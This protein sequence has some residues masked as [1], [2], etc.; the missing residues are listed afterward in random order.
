MFSKKLPVT[1]F[2]DNAGRVWNAAIDINTVKRVR[3]LTGVDI[4]D[5][6]KVIEDAASDPVLLC[7]VLYAICKPQADAA[8]VSDE[9]FGAALVGNTIADAA[10]ALVQSIID[11]FPEAKRGMLR[12]VLEK[13]RTIENAILTRMK[14]NLNTPELDKKIM[15]MLEGSN[16]H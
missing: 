2:R 15:D 14:E 10:E 16:A 1:S 8:S 12:A 4:V 5:G 13:S 3:Q 7:D 6:I 11:F 9:D